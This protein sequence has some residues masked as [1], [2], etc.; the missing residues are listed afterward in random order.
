[1]ILS[2]LLSGCISK[3]VATKQ[4]GNLYEVVQGEVYDSQ[5][6]TGIVTD[7]YSVTNLLA[8]ISNLKNTNESNFCIVSPLLGQGGFSYSVQFS[9][10]QPAT[11]T[12]K[13]IKE[14]MFGAAVLN[15]RIVCFITDISTD[16]P[17]IVQLNN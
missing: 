1:M 14:D 6:Q 5:E 8:S 17:R 15:H 2:Y 3:Q 12:V 13:L 10:G 9:D 11:L 16:I 4:G 7:K